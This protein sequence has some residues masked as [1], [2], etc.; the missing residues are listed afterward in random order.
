MPE[1]VRP[2]VF[3]THDESIFNCNDG[4]K[5]IWIHEDKAPLCKKGRAPGLHV[6]DFLSSIRRLR[7]GTV[8]EIFKCGGDVWWTG[9]DMLEQVTQKAIPAFERSFPECQALFAFDKAKSHQKY[10]LDALLTRNINLN[11]GGKNMI[12]M[13]DGWHFKEG[14]SGEIQKQSMML[15]DGRSK[16]LRIVLHERGLWPQ[17]RKLLT[18]SSILGDSPGT[19][20]LNPACKYASDA[21]CCAH[22]LLSSQPDFQQQKSELQETIEAA[23]HQVI[24][25]PVYHCELNFIEYFWGRAKLYA[26]A[27][28]EYSFPALVCIVREALAQ[29]SEQLIYK[30]YQRVLRI[31]EAYRNHLAYGSDDFKRHV[32]TRYSSHR[33][34]AESDLNFS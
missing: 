26:R 34:I 19:T 2:I 23:G 29:V 16:G 22:A 15:T 12:P 8:C 28:C 13:R 4:R 10:V 9:E 20:K 1:C 7:D 5:R 18:Q 27:H 24:F 32:F 21:S 17:G 25:Y 3:I 31:M 33:R 14:N 6:S 11:P 30:Y